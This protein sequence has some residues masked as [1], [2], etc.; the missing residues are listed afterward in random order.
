MKKINKNLLIIFLNLTITISG[1]SQSKD[2]YLIKVFKG[3][4]DEPGVE[5]GYINLKGDTIIP[6]GINFPHIASL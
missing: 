4:Y 5:S 3:E 6:I 2:D 1:F